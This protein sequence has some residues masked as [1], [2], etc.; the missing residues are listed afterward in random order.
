MPLFL[1]ITLV[2]ALFALFTKHRQ[3]AFELVSKTRVVVAQEEMQH[4]SVPA[5]TPA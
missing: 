5:S 3:R 4:H 1:Q 2:D